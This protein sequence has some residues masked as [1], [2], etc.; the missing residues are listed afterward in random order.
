MI[1][2]DEILNIYKSKQ[3]DEFLKKYTKIDLNKKGL[4]YKDVSNFFK[5]LGNNPSNG[6]NIGQLQHSEKGLVERITNAIDAVI[7]KQKQKFNIQYAPDSETIIK[8]AYYDYYEIMRKVRSEKID[9]MDAKN[10]DKEVLLVVNDG[11]K[12]N[13]PTF[14]VIDK[15]TGLLGNEFENTILSINHGNKLSRDKSYLIGAFGQGG[16]TSLPFTYATIIL[17][18]KNNKM[19]FTIVKRVDL[20]DY[21]N[22][23]YMYL[24]LNKEIPEVDFSYFNTS[25]PYL[26]DFI[27]NDSGTLIRMVELEIQ[28]RFISNEVVKPRMLCDYL[29]TELFDVKLPIKVI[30]NRQNYK[31]NANLQNRSVF[32]SQ[33]K[34]KTWK[35][36][37]K[38]YCGSLNIEHNDHAFKIDYYII[39]PNDENKWG[40]ESECKDAFGQINSY[41]DPIIY[42]VNGQTITTEKYTKLGNAGL[43]FLKY[44][45]LVVINLDG[46]GNEKYKFFTTDRS[47]IV[48]SDLTH[49]FLEKVISQLSLSKKL[50]E[51]DNIIANKSVA[52]EINSDEWKDIS[53]EIKKEY[54]KYLKNGKLMPSNPGKH[55][56]ED[57]IN[58]YEDHIEFLKITSTKREFCKDENVDIVV[59]TNADL[60]VNQSAN[61]SCFVNDK[62]F[63][64]INKNSMKGRIQFTIDAGI[65]KPGIYLLYF[66]YFNNNDQKSIESEKIQIKIKNEISPEIKRNSPTKILDIIPIQVKDAILICDINTNEVEKK[67][68]IK[69]CLDNDLMVRE[70]Y[71]YSAS[72]DEISR[73]KKQIIKPISLFCLH[74]KDF[75]TE[76]KNDEDK[77]KIVLSLIKSYISSTKLKEN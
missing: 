20:N 74:L 32:G 24:I 36:V 55:Y 26:R 2:I 39:L 17:S 29:N 35:Y 46:L 51:I 12:S 38:D 15:G 16:S 70:I 27:E 43:S 19:W 61:I 33:L 63:W 22:A 44:R 23:A 40:I 52:S 34:L 53:N 10:A 62:N 77:N 31:N 5:F 13:T 30:E 41:Y 18:K 59:T 42:T 71:G 8:K 72:S 21:K 50:K 64:N 11:S 4:Y 48:D 73:I 60:Y 68:Y 45:L 76:I 14:D 58:K 25:D 65:I 7:E 69:L 56:K 28:K 3:V 75:Y 49:G 66:M 54:S 57:K 6:S 1:E 9:R 37:K 47:R 67:I